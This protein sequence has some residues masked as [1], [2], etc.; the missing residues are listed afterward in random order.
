LK[1]RRGPNP[2]FENVADARK[3]VERVL[4]MFAQRFGGCFVTLLAMFLVSFAVLHRPV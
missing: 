1:G 3:G 4:Q 2:G